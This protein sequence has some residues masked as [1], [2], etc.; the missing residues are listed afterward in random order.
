MRSA[1]LAIIGVVL[2]VTVS[3]P[4][5]V[6]GQERTW[7]F[8]QVRVPGAQP[9]GKHG[10][11]ATVA[12]V[13]TWVD[14]EHP[15]LEGRVVSHAVCIDTCRDR[16]AQPDRCEHGTHVAGT[17]A[18]ARYGV[19]PQARV[20]A[21]QVL[22]YDR[23]TGVCSGSASD[24]AAAIKFA[25]ARGADVVNLSVGDLVPGVFSNAKVAAAVRDA[26]QA[27][28]L[29]VFAAGNS[30]VPV[31][32]DYGDDALLVA[33]TGPDGGLATYS[34][35]GGSVALAAPGGDDGAAGLAACR[36]ENCIRSTLPGGRF[37]LLEGTSM[38][39]PHVSGVAALLVAQNPQRGRRDVV[40]ALASTARPMSGTRYGLIDATGALRPQ[41][42]APTTTTT[43]RPEASNPVRNPDAGPPA[44]DD[45]TRAAA[46]PN[47]PPSSRLKFSL[48]PVQTPG[49]DEFTRPRAAVPPPDEAASPTPVFVFG[50]LAALALAGALWSALRSS[51]Q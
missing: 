19:A 49:D 44:R 37:G 13:D 11:G 32:D 16:T 42:P 6:A 25:A 34:T 39:A 28:V 41:A 15:D 35:R 12:V 4:T 47:P 38:A 45:P 36:P 23:D 31:S 8:D 17:V 1:L 22:T 33:A 14:F 18:S 46:V 21:I 43:V 2:A 29:V 30:S 3:M 10:A 51:R 7:N 40:R 27:G 50:G 5:A 9:L 20:L 24:V 48:P 26:A